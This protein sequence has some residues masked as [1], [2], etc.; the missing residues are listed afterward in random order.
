[1][2]VENGVGGRMRDVYCTV[3]YHFPDGNAG[4]EKKMKSK[5]KICTR[6]SEKQGQDSTE[7]RRSCRIIFEKWVW[8]RSRGSRTAVLAYGFTESLKFR[9]YITLY[10]IRFPDDACKLLF[11]DCL[12]FPIN[13][14][15]RRVRF[16][17]CRVNK[18]H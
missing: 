17:N 9:I 7:L 1:M 18:R 14:T 8:I 11:G 6:S 13:G 10:P 4:G 16:K 12:L 5:I 3:F 15:I 2:T